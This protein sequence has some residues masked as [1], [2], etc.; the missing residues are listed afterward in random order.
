MSLKEEENPKT[1]LKDV[2]GILVKT[3]QERLQSLTYKLR[4]SPEDNIIHGLCLIILHKEVQALKKF[5][6]LKDNCLAKDLAEKWH[7]SGGKLEDF[8]V[9]CGHLDESHA[10]SLVLLARI[11]K[12]LSEEGLCDPLLRDLAYKRA[13]FTGFQKTNKCENLEYNQFKEE[14]MAVCGPQFAEMFSSFRDLKLNSDQ[15]L[16]NSLDEGNTALTLSLSKSPSQSSECLPSPLKAG[17][18]MPSYPTH[19]EISIAP[20]ATFQEE[21]ITQGTS[22]D[23][24]PSTAVTLD[25]GQAM[26]KAGGHCQSSEESQLKSNDP[27]N[28]KTVTGSA[29]GSSKSGGHSIQLQNPNQASVPATHPKCALPSAS[30][31]T[32]LEKKLESLCAEEEEEV[33][34]YSFVIL[35][36]P[37]DADVADRIKERIESAISCEGATFS[38]DFSIPGKSTLMSIEDAIS[39]SAYTLLL[40]TQNFITSGLLEMKANSALINSI[41]NKHKRDTVIP[42]LPRENSIPR[43]SIPLV[44]RTLVALEENNRFDTRI[45]KA[46]SRGRI[47]TQREVWE[48]EQKVKRMREKQERLKVLNRKQEQ[49]NEE[50]R[51]IQQLEQEHLELLRQQRS[52]FLRPTDVP[53]GH[54][55]EDG[56]AWWQQTPSIHIENAQYIMI[57]NNSHMNVEHGGGAERDDFIHR[58]EEQ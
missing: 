48:K 42:L 46:L 24:N 15:D 32:V 50:S 6:M 33:K 26:P 38:E 16:Y 21:K 47:E 8:A 12:V 17:S 19:L 9:R 4:D 40:L 7:M 49:V 56:V 10:D 52:R 51:R 14:A 2:F 29:A 31:V 43:D 37:E 44:L 36:A 45:Q 1:G 11:F 5:Q 28:S 34:F 20:T 39:N 22:A 35:H 3:P 27:Q 55:R 18:L 41:Y 58:E 30:N 23:T 57:G 53:P 54:H 25:S 13:L